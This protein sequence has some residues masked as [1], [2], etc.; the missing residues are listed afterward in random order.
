MTVLW[1]NGSAS[2]SP[3]TVTSEYGPRTHPVTGVQ[4]SFH[5]GI[6]LIGWS[7][8]KAPVSGQVIFA[9]YN[10][11]AGN[12]VRIRG[13][14]GHVYRLFHNR[15][16]WV[17]SGQWVSQG[18]D[19]AVMG[20]TG[21]STGVHCHYQIEV[22][23]STVN[24]RNYMWAANSGSAPAGNEDD[25]MTPEQDAR[26][27]NIEALLAGTGPSLQDPNWHAGQ[28]SVLQ[29]L[30]NLTGFVW[31]GGTS[32]KDPN[33]FGAPGSL[34]YLAKS[35]VIRT[36]PDPANPGKT[37]TVPIS[38][39]QDNADTNT[40]VRELL[41]RPAISLTPEQL[42]EIAKDLADAGVGGASA[43]QVEEIVK[44]ALESLVLVPQTPAA[45][46]PEPTK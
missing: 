33:F 7:I 20:T 15:E 2:Q 24:P 4:N 9:G 5:Y 10:G 34:Y 32:V 14:N 30:Q 8:I 45:A 29:H 25:D 16:L 3:P 26:L 22:G 27:R 23:G 35:N 40:M 19:V 39:I 13:N 43:E 42:S 21:S 38:Q 18:Q 17:K 44:A 12:E 28:G 11:G 41:A 1:P 6:D 36:V 31:A 37:K 46:A